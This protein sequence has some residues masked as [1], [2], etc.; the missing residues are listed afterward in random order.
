VVDIAAHRDVFNTPILQED[1]HGETMGG[2][3]REVR[4][5][6]GVGK[7]RQPITLEQHRQHDFHLKRG[8][9]CADA[10][11]VSGTERQVLVW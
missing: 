7:Q 5:D 8:E 1:A 4:V 3:H 2:T 6:P 10:A 9:F 11:V